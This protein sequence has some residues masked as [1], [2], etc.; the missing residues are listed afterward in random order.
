M[1]VLFKSYSKPTAKFSLIPERPE[2][3]ILNPNSK[4]KINPHFSTF[5]GKN[6]EIIFQ[7][8]VL[9]FLLNNKHKHNH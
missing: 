9:Y 6:T 1:R 5:M 4:W 8:S 7:T 3:E 2:P